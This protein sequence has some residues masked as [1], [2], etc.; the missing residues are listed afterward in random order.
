MFFNRQISLNWL[1]NDHHIGHIT[2]LGK[3]NTT[4]V[5]STSCETK[6]QTF[7]FFPFLFL[8]K[9]EKIMSFFEQN[10]VIFP[11]K[12][13]ENFGCFSPNFK[14]QI[15]GKKLAKFFFIKNH[16]IENM[17]LEEKE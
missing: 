9:G 16:K 14:I 8:F 3:K 13:G 10:F 2:K 5:G 7:S 1:V 15:L 6:F 12:I 17:T 4:L 11:Q